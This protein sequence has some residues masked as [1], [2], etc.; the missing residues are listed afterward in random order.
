MW[1][2][3]GLG[4]L[5][6]PAL[7][8]SDGLDG[9]CSIDHRTF[10]DLECPD[11]FKER[12]WAT[13]TNGK[14]SPCCPEGMDLVWPPTRISQYRVVAYRHGTQAV[15]SYVPCEKLKIVVE[16]LGMEYKFL[17]MILYAFRPGDAEETKV[18]S[19]TVPGHLG[20][21][22]HT[23]SECENNSVVTHRN[24]V[25]K[26][27]KSAFYFM[28]PN[29]GSGPIKFRLLVKFGETNGG[30]F[31]LPSRDL[32]LR[33]S[34]TAISHMWVQS[35]EGESC[36]AAC[37]VAGGSCDA[38]AMGQNLGKAWPAQYN[39]GPEQWVT[40]P[41]PSMKAD[42]QACSARQGLTVDAE[43]NCWY[44]LDGTCTP[45]CEETITGHS[46]ICACT[47]PSN[48][49]EW[50]SAYDPMPGAS[51]LA[52]TRR[53]AQA[54][55]TALALLVTATHMQSPASWLTVFAG[56]VVAMVPQSAAAHIWM[57][58]MRC[59]SLAGP[60]VETSNADVC[61]GNVAN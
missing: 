13:T 38:S 50:C 46:R 37:T 26:L 8:N 19:W 44:R 9:T 58:T 36:A 55:M 24:A 4:I 20:D 12:P 32:E 59:A 7:G 39:E 16:V 35:D 6:H 33:E 34:S 1:I 11:K 30:K 14:M 18:G 42:G 49:F 48:G 61:R 56:L 41:Q 47:V 52:G 2:V 23:P 27:Y 45:T 17:G 29:S 21:L 53:S 5:A 43:G 15:N 28:P 51:V 54:S 22:F 60:L 40:C 3:A 25:T 57:N 31:Y 10:C